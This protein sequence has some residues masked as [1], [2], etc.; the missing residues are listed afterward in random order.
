M[1]VDSWLSV[2]PLQGARTLHYFL[3]RGTSLSFENFAV[4]DY[5]VGRLLVLRNVKV[6]GYRESLKKSFAV[7]T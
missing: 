6:W 7:F 5:V 4:K 1:L 2:R 3:Y